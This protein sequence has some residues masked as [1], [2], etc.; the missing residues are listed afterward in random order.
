MA[1]QKRPAARGQKN[2]SATTAA[3]PLIAC[4]IIRAGKPVFAV[5]SGTKTTADKIRQQT[6]APSPIDILLYYSTI[7]ALEALYA[8]GAKPCK[9][10]ASPI[11]IVAL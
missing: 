1:D 7:T 10:S 11:F 8:F 2:A 5:S 3:S 6:H 9:K 4:S